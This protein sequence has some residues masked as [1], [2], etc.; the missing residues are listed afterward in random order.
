MITAIILIGIAILWLIANNEFNESGSMVAR[1]KRAS[2]VWAFAG[3]VLGS[4][5][6]FAG[7]GEAIAGTIPGAIF[8][9]LV[10]S[11]LMYRQ[12]LGEPA[13]HNPTKIINSLFSIAK[14]LASSTL[15]L[16]RKLFLIITRLALMAF[17]LTM[18]ILG[19]NLY[20][21]SDSQQLPKNS[22]QATDQSEKYNAAV[23]DI[24]SQYPQLNPD[25]PQYSQALASKV[26]NIFNTY[27]AQGYQP[28]V[29][30]NIAVQ[31][32]MQPAQKATATAVQAQKYTAEPIN[33]QQIKKPSKRT[34]SGEVNCVYKDVM[35]DADYRACGI[36]PPKTN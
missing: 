36:N 10:A 22:Q 16:G 7:F 25:S 18:L 33:P 34:R 3:G 23:K 4:F 28:D 2:F 21:S 20:R 11:H 26:L 29:A 17:V 35:S 15:T 30:L 31:N 12:F 13:R 6:G 5:T 32:V 27:K 24:E 8:G 19:I 9:Y 14:P 1:R